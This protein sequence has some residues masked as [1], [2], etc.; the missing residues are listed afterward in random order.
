MQLA[1]R[2]YVTTGIAMVG[3][4]AIAVT[5]IS[6]TPHDIHVPAVYSS[7]VQLAALLNPFE[8]FAPIVGQAVANAQ[9][10]GQKVFDNPMPILR[11][12]TLN[13][14]DSAG[15][16]AG[17]GV[18]VAT[19]LATMVLA[20]PGNLQTAIGLLQQG[21][22]DQALKVVENGFVSPF[23]P[24]FMSGLPKLIEVLKRPLIDAQVLLDTLPSSLIVGVG[25]PLLNTAYGLQTQFIN[26]ITGV[27]AALGTGNPEAVVNAII[28]GAAN[29][30]Q[31]LLNGNPANGTHGLLG[32]YGA[33]N[34]FLDARTLAEYFL[35]P[36]AE[37]AARTAA[38]AAVESTP[39]LLVADV[40]SISS[41]SSTA[42][43]AISGA[44]TVTLSPA[45]ETP[46]A[47]TPVAETP[48]AETPVE[49]TPVAE[50][51]VEDT[52]VA[53]TPV[54]ETPAA[55][56]PVVDAEP[57]VETE[58]TTLVRDSAQAKPGQLGLTK[59]SE[60]GAGL[61]KSVRGEISKVASK[62]D[63]GIKKAF[64]QPTKTAAT[65]SAG[66][67]SSDTGSNE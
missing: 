54:E 12:L 31:E 4:A 37:F 26:G 19:A 6:V 36:P 57:L 58:P 61:A 32:I 46:A 33:I 60:A 52:P 28:T 63:E 64:G 17:L 20:V 23:I 45:T 5:P 40:S 49:V 21:K 39:D 30:T 1:L 34:G 44:G 15:T 55:E 47:E 66:S 42:V 51:P 56:T 8:V 65:Q 43:S 24:L 11:A 59:A 25:F 53:E 62:I 35:R 67:G 13:Q 38:P 27:V 50:T 22:V 7:D 29:F 41:I 16:L 9:V 10:I 18:D 48:A 14:L 3:A 2:P